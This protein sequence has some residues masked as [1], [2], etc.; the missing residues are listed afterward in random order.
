MVATNEA[1]TVP[2]EYLNR[3]NPASMPPHQLCLKIGMPMI[4]LR[5]LNPKEGLCNGTRL[6]LKNVHNTRFLEATITSGDH[7]G[8]VVFNPRIALQP[9]DDFGFQ[10]QRRQFPIRIA[11]AMTIN[12]AQGQTLKRVGVWLNEPVFTHGQLY[13]AASHVGHL[14]MSALQFK[15]NMILQ[16]VLKILCTLKCSHKCIEQCNK[17]SYT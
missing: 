10:W 17:R 9:G 14:Q 4:L 15:H 5:N 3:L 7:A 12:K 1:I 8:R 16:T 11:F 13:V 2:I 6:L